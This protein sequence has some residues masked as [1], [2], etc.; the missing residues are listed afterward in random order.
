MHD[1][2]RAYPLSIIT[3][4]YCATITIFV[5]PLAAATLYSFSPISFIFFVHTEI[6]TTLILIIRGGSHSPV[7]VKLQSFLLWPLKFLA[8]LQAVVMILHSQKISRAPIFDNFK[9]FLLNFKNFILYLLSKSRNDG[10]YKISY[11]NSATTF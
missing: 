11:H 2:V 4:H 7:M 3:T 9:V 1:T 6:H 5:N 10:C 8:H